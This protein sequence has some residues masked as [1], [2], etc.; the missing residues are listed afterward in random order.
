MMAPQQQH[1]RQFQTNV[2]LQKH[3]SNQSQLTQDRTNQRR[4]TSPS[5][6]ATTAYLFGG[7]LASWNELL[8]N[9]DL[10]PPEGVGL[11]LTAF[12]GLGCREQRGGGCLFAQHIHPH[13]SLSCIGSDGE[14]RSERTTTTQSTMPVSAASATASPAP[15]QRHAQATLQALCRARRKPRVVMVA[16]LLGVACVAFISMLRIMSLDK[17]PKSGSLLRSRLAETADGPTTSVM[18]HSDVDT[19]PEMPPGMLLADDPPAVRK[20][21]RVSKPGS[22]SRR[23]Q[24]QVKKQQRRQQQQQHQKRVQLPQGL[25]YLQSGPVPPGGRRWKPCHDSRPGIDEVSDWSYKRLLQQLGANEGAMGGFTRVNRATDEWASD[26][27]MEMPPPPPPLCKAYLMAHSAV[28]AEYWRPRVHDLLDELVIGY[29]ELLG[30]KPSSRYRKLGEDERP[31]LNRNCW[32]DNEA[33][34]KDERMLCLPEFS[35]LGF[36]KCGTSRTCSHAS[37]AAVVLLATV[38]NPHRL[39]HQRMC[40]VQTLKEHYKRRSTVPWFK[41]R[42]A[43]LS[44]LRFG[45]T[46]I[47]A[48]SCTRTTTS[49]CVLLP[50]PQPQ[51]S[52]RE[53]T[54]THTHT[55]T[56]SDS[57]P[58]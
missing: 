11:L 51:R 47:W 54:H 9:V 44:S 2:N 13:N 5:K 48:A 1:D 31:L 33:K 49:H 30:D 19:E 56:R 3:E 23:R 10:A 8:V 25:P 58:R 41:R 17:A 7:Q 28:A 22:N 4:T 15:G 46:K 26:L 27:P 35:L 6:A 52:T 14:A 18:G 12:K 40:A 39:P 34:E 21:Q 57:S 43:S 20:P 24:Q 45:N 36:A 32:E 16:L 29:S 38:S 55:P 42:G 37:V 53:P 50:S